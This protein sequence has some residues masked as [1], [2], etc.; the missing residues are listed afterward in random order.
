[1]SKTIFIPGMQPSTGGM[2]DAPSR[3]QALRQETDFEN[4][5]QLKEWYANRKETSHDHSPLDVGEKFWDTSTGEKVAAEVLHEE[6]DQHT[7]EIHTTYRTSTTD[8]TSGT[9]R[10]TWAG[11]DD[12]RQI[13]VVSNKRVTD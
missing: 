11:G 5:P 6:K 13:R 10:M 9:K 4:H 3:Y 8:G 1:V 2:D 7:G 12:A